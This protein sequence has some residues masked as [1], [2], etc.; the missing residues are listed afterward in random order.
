[1]LVRRHLLAAT[2]ATL[3][4]LEAVTGCGRGN[5]V[6]SVGTAC[7]SQEVID[8]QVYGADGANI[9]DAI[10]SIND[11]HGP[12]TSVPVTEEGLTDT[13][14]F[15]TA[16]LDNGSYV[17]GASASGYAATS[18]NLV[19]SYPPDASVCTPIDTMLTL[20]P[21]HVDGGA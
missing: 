12:A 13:G 11:L 10:V 21:L 14:C 17:V 20:S 5:S 19:V 8:I 6:L 2:L 1:M 18:Q 9:C 4:S 16:A 15:Y 3:A 7:P